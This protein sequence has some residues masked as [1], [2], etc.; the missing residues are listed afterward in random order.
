MKISTIA[1]HSR[2]SVAVAGLRGDR[3]KILL[4]GLMLS[5]L[6]FVCRSEAGKPVQ[7]LSPASPAASGMPHPSEN[8]NMK[9]TVGEHR[10]AFTPADNDA[11][12][13][14]I[15]MMPLSITMADLHNNEKFAALSKALPVRA[16]QPGKIHSGDLM[17]YGDKTLVVF[18]QTFDSTYSYTPLGRV[19]DPAGLA[20][21][22]GS[23]SVRL[24]FSAE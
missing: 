21:A 9:M 16:S 14:F 24:A 15:A 19:N 3:K 5:S 1:T 11:A 12:R 7:S 22:L 8:T 10:F 18:Y 13:A 6:L 4:Y 20:Q 23:G 2:K 17:L